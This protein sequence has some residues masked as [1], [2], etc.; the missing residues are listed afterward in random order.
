MANQFAD[1]RAKVAQAN[2][3]LGKLAHASTRDSSAGDDNVQV[4]RLQ[5]TKH[6]RQHC[7]VML[8]ISVH[9]GKARS[10]AGHHS[11]DASGRQPPPPDALDDAH[12]WIDQRELADGIGGM[13]RRVIVHKDDLPIETLE[14]GFESGEERSDIRSLFVCGYDHAEFEESVFRRGCNLRS[15]LVACTNHGK[16]S[17]DLSAARG[18]VRVSFPEHAPSRSQPQEKTVLEERCCTL[19]TGYCRVVHGL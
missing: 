6:F 5:E 1:S 3:L 2:A 19:A 12:A 10:R 17:Q 4:P 9:D 14:A 15:Q 16:I 7:F 8:H 11:L 18:I 13:I